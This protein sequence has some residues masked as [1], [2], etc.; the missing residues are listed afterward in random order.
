[1]RAK[2]KEILLTLFVLLL[3]TVVILAVVGFTT[4]FGEYWEWALG[5]LV[6]LTF[7]CIVLYLVYKD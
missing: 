7:I 6:A 1:M 3:L 5:G 4:L 2:A